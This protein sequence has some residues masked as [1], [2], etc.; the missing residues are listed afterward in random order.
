MIP[1][2]MWGLCGMGSVH[3]CSLFAYFE[4]LTTLL[5]LGV[6]A[7]LEDSLRRFPHART[8]KLRGS[9]V[10]PPCVTHSLVSRLVLQSQVGGARSGTDVGASAGPPLPVPQV[11]EPGGTRRLHPGAGPAGHL[12]RQDR[13]RGRG[14]FAHQSPHS[15]LERG[16][17]GGE[18]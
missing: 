9:K 11:F 8:L 17:H 3:R 1:I 10:R 2:G 16:W 5:C 13:G 15:R 14:K 6:A 18:A 7:G 12:P 4:D